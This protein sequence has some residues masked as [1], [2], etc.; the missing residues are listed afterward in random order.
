[1][2]Q[3]II[4]HLPDIFAVLGIIFIGFMFTF[5][6]RTL[7]W[8]GAF[9]CCIVTAVSLVQVFQ[10][11]LG[12]SNVGM[13]AVVAGLLALLV[14]VFQLY[15]VPSPAKS[16]KLGTVSKHA[17]KLYKQE[18]ERARMEELKKRDAHR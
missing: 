1:M 14:L 8:R 10:K 4:K 16:R 6:I 17:N 9:L 15:P 3:T 7:K 11:T 18:R 13:Y 5:E 12:L 2:S